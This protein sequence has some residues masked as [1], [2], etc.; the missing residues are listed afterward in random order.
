MLRVNHWQ[1]LLRVGLRGNQGKGHRKI[2]TEHSRPVLGMQTER[3]ARR[4]V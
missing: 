2:R 4:E 1:K 3:E